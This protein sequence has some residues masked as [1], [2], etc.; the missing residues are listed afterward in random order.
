[1]ER[2][3]SGI[4]FREE[5]QFVIE[6]EVMPLCK[7]I[8]TI[9]FSCVRI[10]STRGTVGSGRCSVPKVRLCSRLSLPSCHPASD[11]GIVGQASLA[12]FMYRSNET[13]RVD[14]RLPKQRDSGL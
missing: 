6:V 14:M 3:R 11:M 8:I 4:W 10:R 7:T 2:S 5:G 9:G 13:S 12:L 1:M